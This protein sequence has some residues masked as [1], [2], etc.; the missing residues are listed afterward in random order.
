[1]RR[2]SSVRGRSDF[3]I[4]VNLYELHMEQ[5]HLDTP[6]YW[7][8][9]KIFCPCRPL[10][11]DSDYLIGMYLVLSILRQPFTSLDDIGP[12][13]EQLIQERLDPRR[14]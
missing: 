12:T 4:L 3:R 13:K 11:I 1:M 9:M 6:E 2:A 8:D 14:G 5:D 10:H 7:S